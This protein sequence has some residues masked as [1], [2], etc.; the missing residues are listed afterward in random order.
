MDD[1]DTV[2]VRTQEGSSQERRSRLLVCSIYTG[3]YRIDLSADHFPVLLQAMK[4]EPPLDAKCRDKFLVQSVAVT[5]DKEF[6]NINEIVRTT[7][8]ASRLRDR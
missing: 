6:T 8:P 3:K 2:S 1:I 7:Q 4:V 5:S